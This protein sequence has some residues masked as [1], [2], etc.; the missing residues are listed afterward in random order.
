MKNESLLGYQESRKIIADLLPVAFW[1]TI[2]EA[3]FLSSNAQ[4]KIIEQSAG[5]LVMMLHAWLL[6]GHKRDIR[7]DREVI[8]FPATPWQFLKQEYAPQWFIRRY[9]V[10]MQKREFVVHIHHH[11]VCP[12]VDMAM[13]KGVHFQWMGEMSGQIPKRNA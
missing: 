5:G 12:H 2:P 11:Y 9:P 4:I 6:D 10:K 3:M 1:N 8:E 13:E 7:E